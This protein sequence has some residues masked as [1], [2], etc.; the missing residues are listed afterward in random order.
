MK[1][2]AALLLAGSCLLSACA[3]A[4]VGAPSAAL[5]K[6]PQSENIG[7]QISAAEYAPPV[8]NSWQVDAPENHGVSPALLEQMHAALAGTPVYA[9]LTVRDDVIVDE[10]YQPGYDAN[11]I[12][13][14]HSAS[15]ALTSALMGIAL[16]EGYIDSIDD[17]P[18]QIPA[19]GA[20]A[21]GWA[22]AQHYPAPAAEPNLR[23]GMVRM[24]RQQPQQL[25]R[26]PVRAQL[27]GIYFKPA[28]A[29]GAGNTV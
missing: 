24:G 27:G 13:P 29:P 5:A 7:W 12:Y 16:Q 10:Y 14:F 26:V 18:L 15:K 25:V 6:L 3:P 20:G 19:P 11:S 4:K 9:V 8:D 2:L 22:Q 21:A 28:P 1:K 17:P 23:A